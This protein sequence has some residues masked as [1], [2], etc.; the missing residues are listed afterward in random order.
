M[1]SIAFVTAAALT[2]SA[3]LSALP[4]SAQTPAPGQAAGEHEFLT[5]DQL[6]WQPAPPGLPPGAEIAVLRGDPGGTDGTFAMRLRVPAG[7]YVAPH[8]HP[9][10]ENLTLVSG[11]MRYGMGDEADEAQTTELPAGTYI[12]LPEGHTHYVWAGDEGFVLEIQAAAPFDITYVDPAND[13]RE[14]QAQ[15]DTSPGTTPGQSAQ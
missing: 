3:A 7:Y 6:E 9:T 1:R 12:F 4:A 11:S 15:A 13:P 14:A 2:L 8:S 5:P 10:A